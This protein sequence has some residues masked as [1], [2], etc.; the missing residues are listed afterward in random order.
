MIPLLKPISL[1]TVVSFS[2]ING[3]HGYNL[4]CYPFHQ[5]LKV[6]DAVDSKPIIIHTGS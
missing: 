2:E 6:G 3:C 5:I 1:I 4:S